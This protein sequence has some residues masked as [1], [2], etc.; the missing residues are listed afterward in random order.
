MQQVLNPIWININ[1]HVLSQQFNNSGRFMR[2][3][4]LQDA[5]IEDDNVY[6]GDHTED[7]NFDVGDNIADSKVDVGYV[8]DEEDN[9]VTQNQRGGD[10]SYDKPKNKGK[11]KLL[12]LGV[13]IHDTEDNYSGGKNNRDN[14]NEEDEETEDIRLNNSPYIVHEDEEEQLL[15]NP[16]KMSG[17]KLVSEWHLPTPFHNSF[18]ACRYNQCKWVADNSIADAVLFRASSVRNWIIEPFPRKPGQRWVVYTSDPAAKMFRLEGTDVANNFNATVTY[19]LH[20]D[21]PRLFGR[22]QR[23]KP[24]VKDYGTQ[25]Y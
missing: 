1:S 8:E 2:Y 20:S 6:S 5:N 13:S 19:Q 3:M 22:L 9:D 24:P 4:K 21:Y 12:D 25:I 15:S 7:A 17:V 23:I 14:T 18:R 10:E 11:S 16:P